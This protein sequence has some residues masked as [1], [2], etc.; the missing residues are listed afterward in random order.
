MKHAGLLAAAA[1]VL[2]ANAFALIHAA[3]NRSGQPEAEI[4]LTERELNYF[5][6]ADDSGVTLNLRWVDL[7]P[8]YYSSALN[9]KDL[10][11]R[12]LLNQA[13]LEALGFDCRVAP[14]DPKA[15]TFYSRPNARNGFV[16]LEYDGAAWQSWIEWRERIEHVPV[17]QKRAIDYERVSGTRLAVIDAGPDAA[18]LRAHYPERNRVLILPAVI[19]MALTPSAP[20]SPP[21]RLRGYIQEIP[22]EIHVP[23]P[24][25]DRLRELSEGGPR[26]YRVRL[27]Y[28]RLLEPWVT[29]IE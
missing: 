6:S 14:S 17:G 11:A 25:S 2:L 22:S 23:R 26:A 5:P 3:V 27:R 8:S 29:G 24:F 9:P 1:I 4:T 21:D 12:T 18:A 20:A 16:A 13:K 15:A 10:E 19:R 7:S 28:G